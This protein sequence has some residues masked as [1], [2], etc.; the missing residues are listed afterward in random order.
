V[1]LKQV[2]STA[3]K[4]VYGPVSSSRLGSSLGVNVT[5]RK[6][7]TCSLDCVYCQYGRTFNLTC[8]PEFAV[9]VEEVLGEVEN[10]LRRLQGQNQQLST[11]TFSG[12]GE[13]T[14]FP[15]LREAVLGVKEL[16]DH[17]YPGVIVDILTNST[18]VTDARACAALKEFDSVVAKLDSGNQ[19]AFVAI[20]RPTARV[21][22]LEKIVENL[23]KLQN[24]TN[25]VTIQT[26]IFKSADP[27]H[28][29]NSTTDEVRGIAENAKLIDPVEV[30]IYTVKRRPAE[31]FAEP[32]DENHLRKARDITND[33]MKKNCARIYP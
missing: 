7:K 31:S 24:E 30:Q 13:P 14:L 18:T 29:D 10:A 16:R 23:A 12:Y 20:N 17:Y 9:S 21:P 33:L 28:H 2:P 19:K 8:T 4:I 11:I 5:P 3:G 27:N 32:V 25:R 6:G 1:T 15:Y 26:L 22:R